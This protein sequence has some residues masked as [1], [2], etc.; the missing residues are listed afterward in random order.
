MTLLRKLPGQGPQLR[1]AHRSGT[2]PIDA[3]AIEENFIGPTRHLSDHL[4][5]AGNDAHNVAVLLEDR[6]SIR[7]HLSS[8]QSELVPQLRLLRLQVARIVFAGLD[9]DGDF[10]DHR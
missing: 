6:R 7:L 5:L 2:S 3:D 4:D 10:F 1:Q 8:L 9:A